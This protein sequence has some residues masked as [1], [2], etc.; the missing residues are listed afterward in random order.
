MSAEAAQ[1][2]SRRARRTASCAEVPDLA[3]LSGASLGA[4][5]VHVLACLD[6]LEARLAEEPAAEWA[7]DGLR[8]LRAIR[9]D[10]RARLPSYDASRDAVLARLPDFDLPDLPALPDLPDLPDL[11][12]LERLSAALDAPGA[13]L[14]TLSEHLR[15]LQAHLASA[16]AELP[17]A[18][19]LDRV[20]AALSAAPADEDNLLERAAKEL[21]RAAKASM[22]GA[23]LIAYTD[24]PHAWK[25]NHFVSSGYRWVLCSVFASALTGSGSFIPLERW[26]LI[27]L[28]MF[29][30]HNETRMSAR[31]PFRTACPTPHS[32]STSTRT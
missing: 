29:M 20:L 31:P 26:P 5:R 14:P 28:S 8:Q 12:V 27:L 10:V 17:G 7:R 23:K 16:S 9:A 1:R 11:H 4:L 24:L 19:A 22:H 3:A 18:A 2:P 15:S 6:A 30:I 32:Q 21:T 25:N 13:Y